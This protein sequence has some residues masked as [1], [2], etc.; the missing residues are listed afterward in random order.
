MDHPIQTRRPDIVLSNKKKK[1][2]NNNDNNTSRKM[3]L[4]KF[5]GTLKYKRITESWSENQI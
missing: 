2:Y 3:W 1:I 5:S 4:H